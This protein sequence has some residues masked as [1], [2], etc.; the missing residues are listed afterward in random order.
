M[1]TIF[2]NVTTENVDY[3]SQIIM[4]SLIAI[5]SLLFILCLIVLLHSL[6]RTK[7]WNMVK[8][9]KMLLPWPILGMFF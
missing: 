7:K 3:A 1:V 8:L 6:F 9:L 4:Y 5:F 2:P